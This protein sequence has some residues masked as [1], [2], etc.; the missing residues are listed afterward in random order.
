[1]LAFATAIVGCSSAP[2]KTVALDH[3]GTRRTLLAK[4]GEIRDALMTLV[5]RDPQYTVTEAGDT[6]N[7]AF[8]NG[9]EQWGLTAYLEPG[10]SGDQGDIEIVCQ[11]PAT[12]EARRKLE[13]EWLDKLPEAVKYLAL[14]HVP[15]LRSPLDEGPRAVLPSV[16]PAVDAVRRY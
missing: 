13:K 10:D 12:E 6:V 16:A 7:V 5:T 4:K 3:G 9:S 1:M 8:R 15:D 2:K 14:D 11:G